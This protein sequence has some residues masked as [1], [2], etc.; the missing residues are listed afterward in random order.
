MISQPT[1]CSWR[2]GFVCDDW[3]DI[4]LAAAS[5]NYHGM[6]QRGGTERARQTNA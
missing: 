3:Y 1:I 2:E 4:F 6:R 5:Q